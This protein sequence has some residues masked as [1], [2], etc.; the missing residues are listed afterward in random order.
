MQK[1]QN[2]NKIFTKLFGNRYLGTKYYNK[3]TRK[4]KTA[5]IYLT[6]NYK[7]AIG[8]IDSISTPRRNSRVLNDK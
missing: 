2:T 8:K 7:T 6:G 4:V 3:N 1:Q 5:E